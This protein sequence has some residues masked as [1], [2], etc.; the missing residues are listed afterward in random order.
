MKL[1]FKRDE[2]AAMDSE[3][4]TFLKIMSCDCSEK[5]RNMFGLASPIQEFCLW[6]FVYVVQTAKYVQNSTKNSDISSNGKQ[7]KTDLQLEAKRT[8]SVNGRIFIKKTTLSAS[9]E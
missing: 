6:R 2:W 4:F 5:K 1:K 9:F 3:V 8:R 7:A